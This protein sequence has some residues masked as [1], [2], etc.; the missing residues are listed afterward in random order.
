MARPTF[1]FRGDLSDT[2]VEILKTGSRAMSV[3]ALLKLQTKTPPERDLRTDGE[4]YCRGLQ[5]STERT[6]RKSMRFT[7]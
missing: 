3:A 6:R 1:A 4:V 2:V 7:Q 5:Y